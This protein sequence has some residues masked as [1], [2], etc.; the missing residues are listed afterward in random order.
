MFVTGITERVELGEG[1]WI[2]VRKLSAKQLANA[3]RAREREVGEL[4][5]TFGGDVMASVQRAR[6]DGAVADA[7]A[8]ADDD[9]L[10]TYERWSVLRDGIVAWSSERKVNVPA[11][12]DLDEATVTLVARA[13]L[14]LSLPPRD[15]ATRG[16]A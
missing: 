6:Q 2:E 1:E 16:N 3:S 4:L 15:E 12:E 13:I 10:T 8:A 11:I 9:P 7:V 14:A 5:R